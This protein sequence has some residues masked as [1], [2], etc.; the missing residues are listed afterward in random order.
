MGQV[1]ENHRQIV[2]EIHRFAGGKWW[3][4]G[5]CLLPEMLLL[6][7]LGF[8]AFVGWSDRGGAFHPVTWGNRL[9]L[10]PLVILAAEVI[11]ATLVAMALSISLSFVK[12]G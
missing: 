8:A 11:W 5:L 3:K 1:S 7:A 10:L 6:L 12:K 2:L 4:A 9:L